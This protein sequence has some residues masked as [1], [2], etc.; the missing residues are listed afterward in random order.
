MQM[1]IVT[2]RDYAES[3]SNESLHPEPSLSG[4]DSVL[5]QKGSGLYEIRVKETELA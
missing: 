1:F 3:L 2:R 4:S 5:G